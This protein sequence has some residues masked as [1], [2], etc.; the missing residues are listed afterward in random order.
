TLIEQIVDKLRFEASASEITIE[1]E[2]GPLY[3]I[4]IDVMLINRVLANLVGNAITYAGKGK[5]IKITTWDDDEWAYIE[6]ADTGVGI[7]EA[8]IETIV[9]QLYRVKNGSNHQ[10]KGSGLGLYL[11]KYFIE[12]HQGKIRVK[13]TRGQGNQFVIQLKNA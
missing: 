12:L 3:P 10:I 11:V 1:K 4:Q 9:D 5:N 2:L 13:A 6:I 7:A 8:D